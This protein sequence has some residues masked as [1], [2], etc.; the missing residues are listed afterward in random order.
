LKSNENNKLQ[1]R[2]FVVFF[3]PRQNTYILTKNVKLG[4]KH[5]MANW[6]ECRDSSF[7]PGRDSSFKLGR[8]RPSYSL[9]AIIIIINVASSMPKVA[10]IF[11]MTFFHA[12][13]S[14]SLFPILLNI[15]LFVTFSIQLT[16]R[17]LR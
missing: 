8:D 14:K 17:I 10:Y 12:F 6:P 5:K 7:K 3:F 1:T 15:S 2:W 11:F 9:Q 13:R 4:Q 16:L